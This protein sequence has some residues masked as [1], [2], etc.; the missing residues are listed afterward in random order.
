MQALPLKPDPLQEVHNSKTGLYRMTPGIDR[1]I[2]GDSTQA[3]H[4][5]VR[6][7]WDADKNYRP[8]T[9]KKHFQ[10]TRDPRGT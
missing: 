6:A 8:A 4:D 2:G 7:R 5:S 9:L 10:D 1:T 3:V